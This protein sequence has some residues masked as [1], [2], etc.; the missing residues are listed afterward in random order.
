MKRI[1]TSL[2][3][4]SLLG[5]AAVSTDKEGTRLYRDQVLQIKPGV[6]TRQAAMDLF[7]EPTEITSEG[8]QERFTYTFKEK[9]TR[10]YFGG[11]VEDQ[12]KQREATTKLELIIRDGIV[13]SYN[14]S[15]MEE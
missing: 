12:T 8:D 9:K 4:I 7:G 1:L 13:Y 5:C 3:V 10:S 14:F 2:L 11:L 6:T 15:S